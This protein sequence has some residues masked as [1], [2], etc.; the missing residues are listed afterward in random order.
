MKNMKKNI[1]L[2]LLV[3]MLINNARVVSGQ[4]AFTLIQSLET[5]AGLVTADHLGQIYLLE[6]SR[7]S[8]LDSNLVFKAA[9]SD[10]KDGVY[11]GSDVS[12]PLKILLFSREFGRIRFIDQNLAPR[13]SAVDLAALQYPN[14][15]LCCSSYES[16]FW[17]YDPA[18]LQVVR[19]NSRAQEVLY[20][21]NLAA[22]AGTD[23]QACFMTEISNMLYLADSL[24]GIFVFDR[25]GAFLKQLPVPGII[26]ICSSGEMIIFIGRE[27][28]FVYDA[29]KAELNELPL[30]CKA[31]SA[32]ITNRKL[33][34][35]SGT[36]LHVYGIL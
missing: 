33:Y 16:G 17:I 5:R 31:V 2:F 29:A 15:S 8:C 7:L 25:Y 36:H 20:S 12:D 1:F 30:P 34:L 22:L 3:L 4:P 35:L 27:L 24:R 18:S 23:V 14:A 32:C 19:F 13:G 10:N 21:G 26:Q 11:A 28:I 9:F 6:G